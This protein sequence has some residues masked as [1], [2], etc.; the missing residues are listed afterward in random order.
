M[1][2]QVGTTRSGFPDFLCNN[3]ANILLFSLFFFFNGS[4]VCHDV[5][6]LHKLGIKRNSNKPESLQ[7]CER[8]I[9]GDDDFSCSVCSHGLA[10]PLFSKFLCFGDSC[11]ALPCNV[12]SRCKT[13]CNSLF[14][15]LYHLQDVPCRLVWFCFCFC[16]FFT[17]R[18]RKV[19]GL[20]LSQQI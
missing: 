7:H 5:S 11:N 12:V 16:F 14:M 19:I 8:H 17:I 1:V 9:S 2:L 4:G 10:A 20:I 18:Q 15:V 6:C 13:L 3:G